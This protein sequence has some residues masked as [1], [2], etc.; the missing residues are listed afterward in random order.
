LGF[1]IPSFANAIHGVGNL[2]ERGWQGDWERWHLVGFV[3]E[4]VLD[5]P[6]D[7]MIGRREGATDSFSERFP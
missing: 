6:V 2:V 7:L 4:S 1:I 5:W 3:K